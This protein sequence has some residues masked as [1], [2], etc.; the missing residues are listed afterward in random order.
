MIV[1]LWSIAAIGSDVGG[2]PPSCGLKE[3]RP[4]SE[5]RKL[6]CVVEQVDIHQV[7]IND[8]GAGNQTHGTFR[9]FSFCL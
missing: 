5:M 8:V 1:P 6:T 2:A 7:Y 9:F 3:I 4:T